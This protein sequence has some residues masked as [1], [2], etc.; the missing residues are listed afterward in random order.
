MTAIHTPVAGE[1]EQALIPQVNLALAPSAYSTG[2]NWYDTPKE[3]RKAV[4]GTVLLILGSI[5]LVTGL[6]LYFRYNKSEY[7]CEETDEL[8]LSAT[9]QIFAAAST[10]MLIPGFILR[11]KYGG[12]NRS[13]RRY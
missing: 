7:T 12:G 4:I 10:G 11:M 5:F 8:F 3:Q 1:V 13:Q 6:Y 2:R 9:G